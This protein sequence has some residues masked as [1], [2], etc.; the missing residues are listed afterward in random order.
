[1]KRYLP[2]ILM[3]IISCLAHAQTITGRVLRMSGDSAVVG[4]SVYYSGSMNGTITNKLGFF[5]LSGGQAKV[6]V[7]VSCVGYNSEVVADYSLDKPITVYLRPK[8]QLMR[9]VQIGSDGMSRLEKE[10]EFKK[11]FIGTSYY[12]INCTIVNLS[13]IDLDYDRDSETLTAFCNKPIIIKNQKLGY[14]INYYLDTFASQSKGH[15]I[16][17]GNYLFKEDTAGVGPTEVRRIKTARENVYEGSRM[18]FVR[19]LWRDKLD[20]ADFEIFDN[21]FKTIPVDSIIYKNAAGEKYVH[22]KTGVRIAYKKDYHNLGLLSARE[23]WSFINKN[24]FY[25]SG[26][27]WTGRMSY[28]RVGDMLPFEFVSPLDDKK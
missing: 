1:M 7:I 20:K 21:L 9:E 19:M 23:R 24:G 26:L 18:Q 15:I 8:T 11:Q 2:L 3:L 22:L 5:S 16:Y 10:R 4:A 13:E 27:I 28:Q 14:I 12:A 6:P 25:R 17:S